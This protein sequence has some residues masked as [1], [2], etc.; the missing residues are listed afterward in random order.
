MT[1]NLE[2]N[3]ARLAA[4]EHLQTPEEVLKEL[5]KLTNL[6]EEDLKELSKPLSEMSKAL[7]NQH[8]DENG[9]FDLDA[10]ALKQLQKYA[11]ETVD[12]I[13]AKYGDP[14]DLNGPLKENIGKIADLFI[15]E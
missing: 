4:Y 1:A 8:L 7:L 13:K 15:L 2:I 10:Q 14:H 11:R 6:P 3:E 9:N 12:I 5:K